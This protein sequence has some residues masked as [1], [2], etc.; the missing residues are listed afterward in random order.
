MKVVHLDGTGKD[1][2]K[3]CEIIDGWPRDKKLSWNSLLDVIE[4]HMHNRWSRQALDRHERISQAFQLKKK[5]LRNLPPPKP[6][7][8]DIPDDIRKLME[9]INWLESKCQRLEEEIRALLEQFARWAYNA[10]AAGL[11]E[12]QLNKAI[13]AVDRRP[14]TDD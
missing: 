3:I 5:S 2:A 6:E 14:S 12:E 9:V 8:K 10:H 7:A 4:L 13:P 11:T 1:I